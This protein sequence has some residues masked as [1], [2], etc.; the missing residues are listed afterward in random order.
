MPT[1]IFIIIYFIGN[2]LLSMNVQKSNERILTTIKKRMPYR[3][4][5]RFA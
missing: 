1:Y 2:R 3:I 4:Y 5:D